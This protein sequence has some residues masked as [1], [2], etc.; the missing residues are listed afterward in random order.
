[1][2]MITLDVSPAIINRTAVY[3]MIMDLGERLSADFNTELS[4]VGKNIG[5]NQSP[6]FIHSLNSKRG[7]VWKSLFPTI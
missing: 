5:C 3:H 2:K 6:A 7:K 1:M 4:V